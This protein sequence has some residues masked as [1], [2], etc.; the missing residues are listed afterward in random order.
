MKA[1]VYLEMPELVSVAKEVRLTETEKKRYDEL[2]K[3]LVL[4]LPSGEVTAANA[5]SLTLK[6]SQMANGERRDLYRWQGRGGHP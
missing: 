4:E 2:K 1:T 5:A 3:S 6:L